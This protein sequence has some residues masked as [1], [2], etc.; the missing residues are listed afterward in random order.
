MRVLSKIELE[1]VSGGSAWDD[2]WY[3]VG[4]AVGN[5]FDNS[6]E[7]AEAEG[8]TAADP[9]EGFDFGGCN[10]QCPW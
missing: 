6:D 4:Y 1:N 3:N 7:L 8:S 5:F 10:D 2:F 9:S